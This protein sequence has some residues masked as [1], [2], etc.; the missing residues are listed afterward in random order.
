MATTQTHEACLCASHDVIDER[1]TL[2]F[3]SSSWLKRRLGT[4]YFFFSFRLHPWRC[5]IWLYGIRAVMGLDVE[6]QGVLEC[7]DSMAV[8]AEQIDKSQGRP[9]LLRFYSYLSWW[10]SPSLSNRLYRLGRVASVSSSPGLF[11]P[12]YDVDSGT[13]R[14]QVV[15]SLKATSSAHI[16]EGDRCRRTSIPNAAI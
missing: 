3:P 7:E 4:S 9:R 1:L 11:L 15:A 16:L 13:G 6:M 14:S 8:R 12:S 2:C 10:H 5:L